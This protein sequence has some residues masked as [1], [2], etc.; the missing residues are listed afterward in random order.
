[1][2]QGALSPERAIGPSKS[3]EAL[4]NTLSKNRNWHEEI[5]PRI[6]TNF[7]QKPFNISRVYV[8]AMGFERE[9]K[10]KKILEST[11][12]PLVFLE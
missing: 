2:G 3:L 4:D 8:S 5:D 11:A 6:A 7:S 12:I 1:M 10:E 9:E